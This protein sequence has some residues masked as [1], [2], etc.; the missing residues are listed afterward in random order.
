MPPSGIKIKQA[1]AHPPS[2]QETHAAGQDHL[3]QAQ[4]LPADEEREAE[5]QDKRREHQAHFL[6]AYRTATE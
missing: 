4:E 3:A 2:R 1:T 5:K 6:I